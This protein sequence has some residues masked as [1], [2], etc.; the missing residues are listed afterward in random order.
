MAN[1]RENQDEKELEKL[2]KRVVSTPFK[3]HDEAKVGISKDSSKPKKRRRR[4]V[5]SEADT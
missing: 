5:D 2:A 4:P 3:P 1:P